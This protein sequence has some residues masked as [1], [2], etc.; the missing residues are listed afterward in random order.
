M[1]NNFPLFK[2][3]FKLSAHQTNLT[4]ELIARLTIFTIMAYILKS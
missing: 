4:T 3:T 2:K 1:A